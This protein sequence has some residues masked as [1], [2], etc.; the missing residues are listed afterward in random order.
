MA[1]RLAVQWHLV[2]QAATRPTVVVAPVRAVLQR[3]GPWHEG[4]EP[5]VVTPGAS[6]HID[7]TV[8]RLVAAGY[9]REHQVEHRGEVAVRGGIIDVF[10]STAEVPVRIDLWGDEV[11]RL[12]AFDV[13]DQRSVA[14][15][16]GAV[17][18]GCREVLATEEVR[19]R[20]A[21]LVDVEPW[22]RSQWERLA[23]G[24]SFDGMESWLPWL[25][26]EEVVLPD[27][28]ADDAQVV[29]VEPRR[30]R[31]RAVEVYD[32][33]GALAETLAA[34]WGLAPRPATRRPPARRPPPSPGSTWGSTG[35]WPA[36]GPPVLSVL[37]VAGRARRPPGDGPGVRA[38]RWRRRPP[39]P[40]GGGP[41]GGPLLGDPVRGHR[42]RS[43]PAVVV[44]ADE[45]VTAP[46]A[47]MAADRAPG[48]RVVTAPLSAGIHPA[49][50]GAGRAGGVRRHRA[51][52]SPPPGPGP[53]PAYRRVL[54][55]PGPGELRGPPPA[56]G[57]P[58]RR[59]DHA[60]HRRHH[61]R[62][63]G[64]RVPRAATGST[65]RSTRSR[66][67]PRT[68]GARRR[69]CRK[70]GGAEWQRSPGQGPGGGG[71]GGRRSW[72]SSTVAAWP[73]RATPSPPTPPGSTRSSRPSPTWRRPTSSGPSPR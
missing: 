37:G 72:S 14:E 1:R 59:R 33:E 47:D 66:R 11:D 19:R 53:G 12:T 68:R 28:L 7:E 21:A 40:P 35:C 6:L 63:P 48:S 57:G 65:C 43:R 34:T 58:L 2:G 10:P 36:A 55:R 20:A 29:L 13:A 15:L 3:L 56:R 26:P 42:G 8:A 32:E 70:M 24:E 61:P 5:Q 31:D 64:A 69:R 17:L 62:L 22:G 39:G 49:R 44:L 51:A 60:G 25:Q 16:D 30:V 41:G 9:R 71:R 38:G 50:A 46:V 18:F 73:W 67:S 23:A 4:A 27:L 45:G 54:R 52:G